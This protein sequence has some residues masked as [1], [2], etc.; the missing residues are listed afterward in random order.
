MPV[1]TKKQIFVAARA[2]A[3]A[4]AKAQGHTPHPMPTLDHVPLYYQE[5]AKAALKATVEEV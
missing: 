2:M 1:I 3:E 4:A 5:M